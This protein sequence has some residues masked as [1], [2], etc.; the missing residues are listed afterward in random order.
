MSHSGRFF[1]PSYRDELRWEGPISGI[2]R[3][4]TSGEWVA[5]SSATRSTAVSIS[6]SQAVWAGVGH[7][8]VWE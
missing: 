1:G 3:E 6:Q 7:R 2:V 5:T 8:F 4:S